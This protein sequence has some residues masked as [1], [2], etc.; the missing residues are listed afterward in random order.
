MYL[1]LLALIL[2]LYSNVHLISLILL[3]AFEETAAPA[4]VD[5]VEAAA[6]DALANALRALQHL[7]LWRLCHHSATHSGQKLVITI[8]FN[9]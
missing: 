4:A 6:S 5:V 7:P 3:T 9:V 2:S 8:D 1:Y